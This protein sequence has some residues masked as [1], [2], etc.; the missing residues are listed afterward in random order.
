MR[1]FALFLLAAVPA[2]AQAQDTP[3][4]SGHCRQVVCGISVDWGTGGTPVNIDRRYGS[5]SDF[6]TVL[7]EQL[8]AAG[9]RFTEDLSS[10]KLTMIVRP[11]VVKALCDVVTGTG[12]D[13][14]C[15]T[16]GEARIEFTTNEA[17]PPKSARVLSRCGEGEYMT[18]RRFAQF[19]AET[20][21]RTLS[22][23]QKKGRPSSKC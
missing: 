11:R 6:P 22:P 2:S 13:E 20:L 4:A 18:V 23:E 17:N 5:L 12:S 16:I 8:K 3:V 14:S 15:N 21:D 7:M 10:V 19:L 9:Y 1:A